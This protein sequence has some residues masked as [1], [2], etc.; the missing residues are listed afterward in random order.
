MTIVKQQTSEQ[1]VKQW[2][3][4]V[5]A[6]QQLFFHLI[7]GNAPSLSRLQNIDGFIQQLQNNQQQ[8]QREVYPDGAAAIRHHIL[9]AMHNLIDSLTKLRDRQ[10][11]QSDLCF[12]VAQVD[13]T[14]V[15]AELLNHRIFD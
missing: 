8:L 1:L 7:N 5:K 11:F 15:Q 2:W 14:M 4:H 12:N 6:R 3:L 10:L 13:M 9:N